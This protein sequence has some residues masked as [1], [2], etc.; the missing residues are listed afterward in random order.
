M[1]Q[2]GSSGAQDSC[3]LVNLVDNRETLRKEIQRVESFDGQGLNRAMR[4]SAKM[5]AN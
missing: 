3:D 1:Q 4:H 2:L 5:E